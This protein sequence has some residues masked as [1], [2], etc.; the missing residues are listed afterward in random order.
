[1]SE[2]IRTLFFLN[3]L[4]LLVFA[5][6]VG[7]VWFFA[8][9]ESIQLWPLPIHIDV[10]IPGD[11]RAW[12]MAH[13]E[14]IT[15]GLMLMAI[16]AGGRFLL[17]NARQHVWFF[18]SAIITAWMFSIPALLNAL[19]G[20]RGLA[21]GGGPFKAGLANDIIYLMGWPPVL[22]VHIMLALGIYGA[23][24]HLRGAARN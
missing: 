8:L 3:G 7:W 14:G 5:I 10:A 6:V 21:F 15:Q 19:F 11:S 17:L 23:F 24:R 16:G 22:G 1:M 18:W 4:G 12:R 9:I 2:R 20:T 13:M